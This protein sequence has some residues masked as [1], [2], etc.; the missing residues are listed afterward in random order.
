MTLNESHL[1]LMSRVLER[2]IG[3]SRHIL[4]AVGLRNCT[5]PHSHDVLTILM[6][7]FMVIMNAKP[8]VVVPPF[9]GSRNTFS[10]IAPD[11]KRP[12][13]I[14]DLQK[15]GRCKSRVLLIFYCLPTKKDLS[16]AA[17]M[18]VMLFCTIS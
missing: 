6:T 5:T 9:P 14:A 17:S 16:N 4:G 15:L 8:F 2:M 11:H 13:P 10:C 12:A 18:N 7:G 1:S 3:V